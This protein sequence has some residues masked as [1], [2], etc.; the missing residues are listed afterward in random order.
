MSPAFRLSAGSG[1]L[2]WPQVLALLA[3]EARTPMGRELALA[4]LPFTDPGAIRHALGETRQARA[5]MGQTGVPPWEGIPDVRPTLETA[6]VAGSVAEAVGPGRADP[7]ARGGGAPARLRPRHPAG[8]RP[9]SRRRSRASRGRPSWP[10]CSGA[11][12][13]PTARC[14]TRRAP[15]LRRVRQRIRDLRRDLVEAARGVL[16]SARRP[17]PSFQE[18]YVTVRHGRYVLP[19]PRG[20]QGPRCAASSTTARRAAPRSSSSRRRWWRPTTTSCRRCARRRAE[21]LRVLAALTDAVRAALPELDGAGGGHRRPRPDL[22]P[23]RARRA[24]GRGRA[25][26]RRRAR[27]RPARR[28]QP[29]APRPE[30]GDRRRGRAVVPIDIELDAERPLLVITG[31]NAGGKTVALKTLGLLALMAQSGCH[32]PAR[33]GARLPV[34]LA[35]ASPSSATSRA[36]PRTSRRSRRSSSSSA[37]CSSAWTPARSSCSTS[38]A[39]APIPTT[40]P[41]WPRR[42]WR[43]LAERG[44]LVRGLHPP[45]AA[46]GLRLDASAGAQRLG[47]VRPRAARADLPARLRS[48]GPELRA[49]HRRPAGPARRADRARARASLGPAAAAPG[50]AGPARRPGP[51]GRR[52]RRAD[53]AARGGERRAARAGPGRARGGAARARARPSPRARGRGAARWSPR[54]GAR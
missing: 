28:A 42:C 54:C 36:W 7:A 13:T 8:G 41:R 9:I 11:R 45:R 30:L 22:R 27:R 5:A 4:T 40:A 12:S 17:T 3:R 49:R 14:A 35:G 31:P 46:Q 20:G 47:R 1:G 29:A 16:R 52:A 10:T 34:V 23:R 50:A 43:T 25:R 24:H 37:R 44:A 15:A 38:W 33:E 39:R 48:P 6:R 53:R 51:Q 26:D 19:D 32:V 18:R 2:E 21:V